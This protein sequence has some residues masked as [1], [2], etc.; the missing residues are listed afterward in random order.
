M[1]KKPLVYRQCSYSHKSFLKKDLFR[2]VKQNGKVYF[3]KYQNMEGRGAYLQ[4][5]LEVIKLA[6]EKNSLSKSLRCQVSEEIYLEL[7]QELSKER[8]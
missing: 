6:Y 5:D 4:K 8:R 1:N 2:V 3:D 7:I